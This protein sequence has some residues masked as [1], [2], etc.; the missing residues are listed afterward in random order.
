[1]AFKTIRCVSHND[2]LGQRY[3]SGTRASAVLG[4]NPYMNN[5]DA[6][7][8]IKRLDKEVDISAKH[9]VMFGKQ[10]E[11]HIRNLF[12]LMKPEYEIIDPPSLEENGYAEVYV[13]ELHSLITASCDGFV[14]ELETG[15]KGILEIKTSE[16]MSARHK[17]QWNG[18]IP[19]NYFI[20]VLHYLMALGSEYEFCEFVYMLKYTDGKDSWY[21]LRN[22]KIERS[23]YI[24]DIKFLQD[25]EMDFITNYIEKGIEPPVII[26]L[27]D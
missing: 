5:K 18:Q 2:W 20:Q 7:R 4:K 16:I 15:R 10:A 24:D 6:Y 3:L 8:Q 22:E 12:K 14:N 27:G 1:M 13:S 21:V 17:E 26:N 9:N 23:K 19:E 11:K 25:R